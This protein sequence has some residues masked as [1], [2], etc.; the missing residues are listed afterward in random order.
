MQ[1]PSSNSR[2]VKLPTP[3][4]HNLNMYVLAASA[5]GVGVMCLA[6]PAQ[7]KIVYTPANINI[8]ENGGLVPLDLNHDGIV[9]FG[10]IDS[11]HTNSGNYAGNLSVLQE[12]RSNRM[13]GAYST[14]P[15]GLVAAKLHKGT[16]IGFDGMFKSAIGSGLV[17]AADNVH[18]ESYGRWKDLNGKSAYLGLRFVIKGK[19]HF[20]W[21]RLKVKVDP[22]AFEV[23]GALTGYAYE[24][25]PNKPILAGAT[26]GQS[27]VNPSTL[28]A[29]ATGR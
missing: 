16:K 10:F 3:I 14:G 25:I 18:Y 28:G 6:P 24:T 1:G 15:R 20:G 11:F 2:I 4:Q 23:F 27:K 22:R 9:D 12:V 5:A 26:K 17:I 7:A 21:A 29:L 19:T 13:W 8:T